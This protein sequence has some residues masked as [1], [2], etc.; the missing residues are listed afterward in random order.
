[1]RLLSIEQR[2]P[3]KLRVRVQ[4]RGHDSAQAVLTLGEATYRLGKLG[5]Q[6]IKTFTLHKPRKSARKDGSK[7]DN[8][9]YR[10]K[11]AKV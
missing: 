5:P 6:Q 1:M 3:G 2:R 10:L 7:A 4:N 8:D 9:N 11:V